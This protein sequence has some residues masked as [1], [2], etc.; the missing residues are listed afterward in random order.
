[1]RGRRLWIKGQ[2][3]GTVIL[4]C[5]RFGRKW[6]DREKAMNRHKVLGEK[7]QCRHRFKIVLFGVWDR[8]S[9]LIGSVSDEESLYRT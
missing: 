6:G 4:K 2:D 7:D 3:N 9:G 5:R 1:M 8:W